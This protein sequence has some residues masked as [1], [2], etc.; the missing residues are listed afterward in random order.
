MTGSV[1]RDAASRFTKA[2]PSAIYDAFVLREAVVQ[3]L[4]PQG[5]TMEIGTSSRALAGA[6]R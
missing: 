5:A 2:S 4:A 1:R 3:W 6:S